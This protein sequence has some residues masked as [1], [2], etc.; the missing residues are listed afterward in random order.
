MI[1]ILHY[2]KDPKLSMGIM[3]YSLLWVNPKPNPKPYTLRSKPKPYFW[4]ILSVIVDKAHQAHQ[5]PRLSLQL[6]Y[7]S[8]L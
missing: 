8:Q 3:V 5:D 4:R 2:L 1:G 6:K 7:S